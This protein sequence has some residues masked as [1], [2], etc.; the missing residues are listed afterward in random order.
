MLLL[1]E[2]EISFFKKVH[3]LS[4]ISHRHS[5]LKWWLSLGHQAGSIEGACNSWSWGHKFKPHVGCKQ[6]LTKGKSYKN[7]KNNVMAFHAVFHDPELLIANCHCSHTDDKYPPAFILHQ[8]I[9]RALFF[10]FFW[11]LESLEV[12]KYIIISGFFREVQ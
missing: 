4:W 3:L 9:A 1:T 6:L 7:K 10:F 2:I 12:L 5:I 8:W 11:W